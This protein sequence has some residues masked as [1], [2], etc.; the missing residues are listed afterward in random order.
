MALMAPF[1]LAIIL[2]YFSPKNL[3]KVSVGAKLGARA[4]VEGTRQRAL[5]PCLGWALK[6][7][8]SL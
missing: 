6:C 4:V 5:L 8:G 3:V 1:A 2:S 7:L